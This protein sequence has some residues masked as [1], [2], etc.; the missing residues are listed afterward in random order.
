MK[1]YVYLILSLQ[2]FCFSHADEIEK[3]LDTVDSKYTYVFHFS[4]PDHGPFTPDQT[5]INQDNK[6]VI[7]QKEGTYTNQSHSISNHPDFG[8]FEIKIPEILQKKVL[9]MNKILESVNIN[10]DYQSSLDSQ[11]F[12]YIYQQKQGNYYKSISFDRRVFQDE[13]ATFF[14]DLDQVSKTLFELEQLMQSSDK[15]K[16]S[17]LISELSYEFEEKGLALTLTFKNKGRYRSAISHPSTWQAKPIGY[18][19]ED[20]YDEWFEVSGGVYTN[21]GYYFQLSLLPEYLDAKKNAKIAKVSAS[22]QYLYLQGNQNIDIH[23]LI[24]YTALQFKN[25][26][27]QAVDLHMLQPENIVNKT[28]SGY[29]YLH[30]FQAGFEAYINRLVKEKGNLENQDIAFPR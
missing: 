8:L 9:K 3:T 30:I 4:S 19:R 10:R 25:E 29:F 20:G 14:Q 18:A 13:N 2:F 24:P 26:Q 28:M 21:Q 11:N 22:N 23:Y 5:V 1:K 16:I 12:S 15:Y 17:M 27:D 7:F 6:L